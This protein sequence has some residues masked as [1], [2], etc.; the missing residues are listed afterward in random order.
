MSYPN[1]PPH[2]DE[3][4]IYNVSPIEPVGG[5]DDGEDELPDYA[6]SQA[7]AQEVQRVAAARRAQELQRKWRAGVGY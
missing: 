6:A 2:Q 1:R 3:L 4:E 7:Q 5:L